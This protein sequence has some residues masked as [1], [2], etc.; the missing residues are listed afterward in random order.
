MHF[1]YDLELPAR[2]ATAWEKYES[3]SN[4]FSNIAG[5]Y[6]AIKLSLEDIR[7][8]FD[9]V[10]DEIIKLIESRLIEDVR[11]IMV[12]GDFSRSPYLVKRINDEF[13]G[14]VGIIVTPEEPGAMLCRGAVLFGLYG[15]DLVYSRR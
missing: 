12:V 4:R 2:L 8:L 3:S 9:P 15:A 1:P 7:S 11:A 5:S 14:R 6:D 10:V 13:S